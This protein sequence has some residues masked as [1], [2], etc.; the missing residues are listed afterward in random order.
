MS[1]MDARDHDNGF[2]TSSNLD[3]GTMCDVSANGF[4]AEHSI[5]NGHGFLDRAKTE[6][7][8]KSLALEV[9]E[10]HSANA[11]LERIVSGLASQDGVALARV[12]LAMPGDIC[13][14]CLMSSECRDRLRCLHLA[15]SAGKP[16]DPADDWSRTTGEF[17]RVPLGA[18]KV[19]YIGSTG[20][21]IL[22]RDHVA[23]SPW[24][25]RPEWAEREGIASF[26]GRPL[27]FRGEI[28][29]VL[30]VFSRTSIKESDFDWLK[31]FA[32]HAALAIANARAF[33]EVAGLRR[34]LEMERD[35]VREEVKEALAFGEVIGQ[36]SAL[37]AVLEQV[38]LVASTDATVLILG[39]SGTGKELI[40]SAI[41]ERSPRRDRAFVRVNC[42]SIPAELFESEFF[43]HAKGSFTGALRDRLGR[44]QLA[45]GGTL[46]LDEVGE[47][48]LAHQAKLLRVLQEG[49]FERVGEDTTRKVN[50]RIV[51]ATNRDLRREAEAGRFRHDLYYRLSVFPMTLPPLRERKE[52]LPALAAHFVRLSCGRTNRPNIKLTKDDLE[53]L[54]GYDWPGNV[55]ELQNAIERAVILARGT[56]LRLDLA[57]THAESQTS[58]EAATG[59]GMVQPSRPGIMRFSDLER[60]QRESIIAAL[61]HARW[62]ISG[63]G[64]AAQLLGINPSTLSSRMKTQGIKRSD[65]A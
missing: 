42:G 48:P 3:L 14:S 37:K 19:G 22:I 27:I 53:L 54:K 9:G 51:A 56:R 25:A 38:E 18:R 15:A 52:D 21:P 1:E 13:E 4:I 61:E 63:T 46:F 55:R 43:G 47:I 45:D 5:A 34:E 39:E 28:L 64:G 17:R 40:A 62:K 31:I 12:W 24:I 60:L 6:T 33:D 57:L 26:A 7:A 65:R 35:Y 30:G 29:G 32:D 11:V 20:E 41:H 59:P 44:F 58:S 8:L 23:E 50:V 2:S 10:A 16:S 49:Q 36:S